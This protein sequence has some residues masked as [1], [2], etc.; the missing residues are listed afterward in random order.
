MNLRRRRYKEIRHI[1]EK[2]KTSEGTTQ[3]KKEG[4]EV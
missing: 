1:R 3:K 4:D 2:K